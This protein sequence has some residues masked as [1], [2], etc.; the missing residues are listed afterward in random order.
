MALF[1][2]AVSEL[3]I[4]QKEGNTGKQKMEELR[5][6]M[7]NAQREAQLIIE[8]ARL[9][10]ERMLYEAQQSADELLEKKNQIEMRLKEFISAER[11]LIK[12][13]ESEEE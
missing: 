2:M 13:Y 5:R 9:K 10:A 12:K 11:D 4:L 3:I 8:E 1:G 6:T 7:L